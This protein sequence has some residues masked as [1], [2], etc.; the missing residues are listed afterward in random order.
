MIAVKQDL[1]VD[2]AVLGIFLVG[3]VRQTLHRA[4][5]PSVKLSRRSSKF[6]CTIHVGEVVAVKGIDPHKLNR[7]MV[8]NRLL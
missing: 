8:T 5:N 1:L 6:R 4:P 2:Y 7:E 3:V